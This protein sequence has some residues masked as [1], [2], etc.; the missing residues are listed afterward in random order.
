MFSYS[1]LPVTGSR[2]FD[3]PVQKSEKKIGENKNKHL[4]MK[5]SAL[6]IG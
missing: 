1:T 4:P 3:E 6:K 2:K 5:I